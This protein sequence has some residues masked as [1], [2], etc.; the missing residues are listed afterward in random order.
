[1][2]EMND[3]TA[4]MC[5]FNGFLLCFFI[6]MFE[7]FQVI[8]MALYYAIGSNNEDSKPHP[9]PK[10]VLGWRERSENI[11]RNHTPGWLEG[12]SMGG[13]VPCYQG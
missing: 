9:S 13:G 12:P 2:W 10:I 1:M 4:G 8:S 7:M 5:F 11:R 3:Q 6:S